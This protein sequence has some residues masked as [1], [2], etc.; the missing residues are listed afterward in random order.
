MLRLE[1]IN[2]AAAFECMDLAG[3]EELHKQD[4]IELM[5]VVKPDWTS[6]AAMEAFAEVHHPPHTTHHT[7]WAIY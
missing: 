4:W 7:P 5:K 2:L 6:A 1:S 3:N